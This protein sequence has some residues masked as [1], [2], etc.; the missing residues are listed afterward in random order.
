MPVTQRRIEK[1]AEQQALWQAA[2]LERFAA[3]DARNLSVE[4][5]RVFAF[6]IPS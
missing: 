4:L 2:R 3:Q 5:H 6:E 1:A